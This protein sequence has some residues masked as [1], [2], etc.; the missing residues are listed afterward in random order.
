MAKTSD[1][2][3]VELSPEDTWAAASDLSRYDEWL[4][5]HDSWRSPIPASGD[6]TKGTKIASIVVVKGTRIRFDWVV[7]KFDPV[8]HVRLKGSGKGGVK[9]KL[10][11]GIVPTSSGSE[12][13][14]TVD[15]GGLPLIGPV[16]KTAALAVSGDLRKS[17]QQFREVFG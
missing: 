2:I 8:S 14:F 7:E 1:S 11:L 4:L 9:A 13:T 17:L 5:I 6:L 16:G 3:E 12:V 15:L 10:D